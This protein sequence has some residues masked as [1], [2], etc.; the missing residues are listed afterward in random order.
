MAKDLN[1]SCNVASGKDMATGT[2]KR[3]LIIW[4]MREQDGEYQREFFQ[5]SP[6]QWENC[7]EN[8]EPFKHGTSSVVIWEEIRKI[9]S[10]PPY[11]DGKNYV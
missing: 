7:P 1:R 3:G 4:Q 5:V 11:L 6:G 8:L 2:R 9:P 10:S